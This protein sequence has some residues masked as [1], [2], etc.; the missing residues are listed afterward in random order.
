[1]GIQAICAGVLA[2]A[3]VFSS[4]AS[5]P[6]A[7][8]GSNRLE[9][10][11]SSNSAAQADMDQAFDGSGNSASRQSSRSGGGSGSSA[12]AISRD[13]TGKPSW[14]DRPN[15]AY[16]PSY[17]VSAVGAGSSRRQAEANAFGN[18]TGRFGQSV[19]NDVKSVESYKQRVISGAVDISSSIEAEQ[20]VQVSSSMESLIGAEI[21]DVW[22]DEKDY[23]AV[24]IME[25]AKVIPI[26]RGLIDANL[27]LISRMTDVPAAR[28]A[29]IET[30]AAYHSAAGI[31]DAN[32]VFATVLSV[33]GGPDMRP[34]LK[35][36]ADYI[37]EADEIAKLIPVNVVVEND[38]EGR[39][40]SAF[41]GVLSDT[42]FRTGNNSSRYV[43]RARVSVTPVDLPNQPNKFSRFV[44]DAAFTDGNTNS[45]LFPFNINGREGHVS[46]SEADQR[47]IRRAESRVKEEYG[48]ALQGYL[49]GSLPQQN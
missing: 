42:G 21:N 37:Y 44:L 24:A 3:L 36:G 16:D 18:L 38:S 15:S 10:A 2:F 32:S 39:I 30:I 35:T 29:T 25:K 43:V 11:R 8:S 22:N 12:P 41:A 46:Q 26:Y 9:R 6:P 7:E 34:D 28:R 1:M 14:V 13:R 47:A 27:S 19:K 17:Y 31:A 48:N 33:L 49:S 20:A 4:C 5:S 23:Y 45:I 40:R